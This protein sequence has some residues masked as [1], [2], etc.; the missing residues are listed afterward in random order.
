MLTSA[1]LHDWHPFVRDRRVRVALDADNAG[2]ANAPTLAAI[3]AHAGAIEIVRERP[4]CK[5]WN[6]TRLTHGRRAA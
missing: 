1:T 6:A 4:L 2:Y 3:L 5:D